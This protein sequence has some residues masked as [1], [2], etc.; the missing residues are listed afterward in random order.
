MRVIIKCFTVIESWLGAFPHT[1]RTRYT[2][3]E[4]ANEHLRRELLLATNKD[5]EVTGKD[6]YEIKCGNGK[7]IYKLIEERIQILEELSS[8]V[9]D[10]EEELE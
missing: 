8:L 1:H 6:C 5:M 2:T 9:S 10:V 7:Y 3:Y 4:L